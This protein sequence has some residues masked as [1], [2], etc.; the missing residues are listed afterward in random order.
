MYLVELMHWRRTR[1]SPWIP[2]ES[3]PTRQKVGTS[4]KNQI[5]EGRAGQAEEAECWTP[6]PRP[7][8]VQGQ[9]K[10]KDQAGVQICY[11]FANG[12][13]LALADRWSLVPLVFRPRRGLI[14]VSIAFPQVIEIVTA[15]ERLEGHRWRLKGSSPTACPKDGLG[16]WKKR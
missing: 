2:V 15:R 16:G 1:R 4:Q 8:Q 10:S 14:N 12:R 9:G 11:S 7:F 3:R 13:G 6:V 5:G